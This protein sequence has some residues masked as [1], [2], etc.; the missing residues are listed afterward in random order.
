VAVREVGEQPLAEQRVVHGDGVPR[1][2]ELRDV[3]VGELVLDRRG[4]V[5][6]R[7]PVA[8]QH[9]GEDLGLELGRRPDAA[10]RLEQPDEGHVRH[11]GGQHLEVQRHRAVRVVEQVLVEERVGDLEP[12]AADHRVVDAARAV[13]EVD[14]V[15][16]EPL[17][18]G[19]RRHLAVTE[20]VQ[21]LGVQRRVGRHDGVVGL[22]HAV[23]GVGT[24]DELDEPLEHRAPELEGQEP[25]LLHG[26]V[27][28]VVARLAE[29]ELRDDPVPAP[30][31]DVGPRRHP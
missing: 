8:R 24:V 12:G 22:L 21:E 20:E 30:H 19:S 26:L 1:C 9:P 3:G 10:E 7:C 14:G 16:V 13:G 31:R 27:V 5:R 11:V 25:E 4:E 18:V 2:V 28:Q 23:P 29:Q 17:D 15:T 6:R